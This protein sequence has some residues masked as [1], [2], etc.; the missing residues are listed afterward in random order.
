MRPKP[1]HGEES[2]LAPSYVFLASKDGRYYSGDIPRADG[3]RDDAVDHRNGERLIRV[4]II[5]TAL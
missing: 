1:D 4:A 2:Y 3:E 5:S